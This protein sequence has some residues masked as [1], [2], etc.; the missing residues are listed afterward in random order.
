MKCSSNQGQSC[1]CSCNGKY[2]SNPALWSKKKKV[3]FLEEH[4]TCLEKQVDDVK[5]TLNELKK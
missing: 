3:E 4:L 1:S 2:S 5:E